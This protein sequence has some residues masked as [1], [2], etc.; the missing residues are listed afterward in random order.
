MRYLCPSADFLHCYLEL[1][2]R[3]EIQGCFRDTDGKGIGNAT[4]EL[5]GGGGAYRLL[6]LYSELCKLTGASGAMSMR[7][8]RRLMQVQSV[9]ALMGVAVQGGR[10][11]IVYCC[12]V[13]PFLFRSSAV[14]ASI[15]RASREALSDCNQAVVHWRLTKT[16]CGDGRIESRFSCRT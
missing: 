7:Q 12:P 6:L 2:D 1:F 11:D 15:C 16:C 8:E 3:P 14:V 4:R 9:G 10:H 5:S 13:M